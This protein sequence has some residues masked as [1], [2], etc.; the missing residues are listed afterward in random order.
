MAR[1]GLGLS[2]AGLGSAVLAAGAGRGYYGSF[3]G[4]AAGWTRLGPSQG[5]DGTP[6]EGSGGTDQQPLQL[7]RGAGVGAL[8][9]RTRGAVQAGCPG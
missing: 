1:A 7:Q 4:A 6:G 5:E 9:G 3:F 2:N 8:R